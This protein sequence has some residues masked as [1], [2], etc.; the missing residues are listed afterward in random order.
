MAVK[1]FNALGRVAKNETDT[2]MW[3][4]GNG[5]KMS[6]KAKTL[7]GIKEYEGAKLGIGFDANIGKLVIKVD[8]TKGEYNCAVNSGNLITNTTVVE[9]MST[10]GNRFKITNNI[11]E[12]YNV[13]EV[14]QENNLQDPDLDVVNEEVAE[15]QF[16]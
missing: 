3:K 4:V 1:L 12:G 9:Q 16:N 8:S 5:F 2:F 14:V 7:L 15:D 6:R 11:V 10:Y 13:I